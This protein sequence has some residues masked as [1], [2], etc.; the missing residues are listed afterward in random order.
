MYAKLGQVNQVAYMTPVL[1]IAERIP[2]PDYKSYS[3]YYDIGL[4]R[5][6]T[7]LTFN[8]F[9]RPACLDTEAL[10]YEKEKVMAT[11]WG[12]RG[13]S[14]STSKLLL[15][16]GLE[17]FSNNECN[18]IYDKDITLRDGII[19]SFQICAGSIANSGDTCE[20]KKKKSSLIKQQ[21][22]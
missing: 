21:S 1:H 7:R 15:K 3:F 6:Q 9:V 13:Y 17:I 20:V 10:L 19:D 18:E 5:L 4:I 12:Q 11:G 8:D 14:Q 2:Y 22:V 16:V